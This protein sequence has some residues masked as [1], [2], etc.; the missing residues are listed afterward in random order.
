MRNDRNSYLSGQLPKIPL[1]HWVIHLW[2]IVKAYLRDFSMKQDILKICPTLSCQCLEILSFVSCLTSLYNI[3]A[4]VESRV[5][6]DPLTNS[7]HKESKL[8]MECHQCAS[9]NNGVDCC[10]Q[11]QTCLIVIKKKRTYVIKTS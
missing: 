6:L 2:P 5:L 3:L 8:H 9:L 7:C 10:C 1:Q 4:A 11:K